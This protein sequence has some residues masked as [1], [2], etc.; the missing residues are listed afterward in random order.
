MGT[1]ARSVWCDL[2]FVHLYSRG[3]CMRVTQISESVLTYACFILAC[4]VQGLATL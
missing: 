3:I 4:P 1:A 2:L